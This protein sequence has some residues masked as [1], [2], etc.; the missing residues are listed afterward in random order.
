MAKI[1][2]A[3]SGVDIDS[4]DDAKREIAKLAGSTFNEK[5]LTQIGLFAGAYDIGH[6][7]VLLSSADG[8][9]TKIKIAAQM[10]IYDTVG[11]DL[12]HHC[13]ND[14][15]VHN[16]TPL[17]FLDYIGHSN[18]TH[19]KIASIVAGLA[20]GCRNIGLALIG[21]ETAQMPSIYP[22]D[23]FDL[24]GFIVGIVRRDEMI[25]GENIRPGDVIIGLPANGLHTNGYSLARKVLFE[26]AKLKADSHIPELGETLGEALLRIH[27]SYLWAIQSL[28]GKVEI[29]G[30]AHITGG[31]VRVNLVRVLPADC[32]AKI[33]KNS[34]PENPI[35]NLIQK[36]GDIEESEMFK[37]FNMGFGYLIIVPESDVDKT[38]DILGKPAFCAGAIVKGERDVELV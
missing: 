28:H 23:E 22:S 4:A 3:S 16:A 7:N 11:I 26:I 36:L 25:T 17:F 18:L 6:D 12:V 2:Y 33:Q 20:K 34:A 29:R 5:V 37:A 32:R 38:L 15:A 8:V 19:R 35:F 30:M 31:G 10:G 13:A 24:V 9:G 21:G 14:I 27:P 1:T